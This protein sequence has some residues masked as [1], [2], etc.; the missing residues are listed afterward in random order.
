MALCITTSMITDEKAE[1]E[2]VWSPYESGS[3]LL[4]AR[5]NNEEAQKIRIECYRDNKAAIDAGG[6]LGEK[7]ALEAEIKAMSEAV[8][9]GWK[10]FID[11]AG[12]EVEFTVDTAKKY[13]TLS[14]DFRKDVQMLSAGREKYLAQN[15]KADA[16][17]AKK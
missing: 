11:E 6:E 4:L 12:A 9:K 5:Y 3:E 2:G 14:K 16:A 8:I 17:K 7:L 10:G 15:L 1:L 13:I